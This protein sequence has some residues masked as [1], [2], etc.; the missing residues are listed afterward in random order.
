[1][2]K[3][4]LWVTSPVKKLVVSYRDIT[5]S[6]APGSQSGDVTAELVYVGRGDRAI[7]Y[8]DKNLSLIH[9]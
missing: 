8:K 2:Y 1:M 3:R 5:A 4:Q 6:L 9:I 7:D